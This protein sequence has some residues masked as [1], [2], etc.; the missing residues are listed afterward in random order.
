MSAN[1]SSSSVEIARDYQIPRNSLALLMVAQA[2]V[3]LPHAAHIS[4]WIVAAALTAGYWRWMVYLGR[5]NYPARWIKTVLVGASGI[6]VALSGS[7]IFSLETFTSL[8]IVAFALKLL[9]MR[10]RRDAYLVIFLG[11]FLVATE[12]LFDQSI[13]I[14]LYELFAAIVVTA[15]MISLN[16]L[17]TRVRPL[18]S[19]KLALTLVFQALP[20]MLVLFLFFPRIAPLWSVPLPSSG[21]TGI[22]DQVAPGDFASLSKSDEIA[23]SVVFKGDIPNPR[24]LYWRGLVYSYF[25]DGLWS[26]VPLPEAEPDTEFEMNVVPGVA[27]EE[28]LTYQVLLEPTQARWLFGLMTPRVESPG[29]ILTADYRLLARDPVNYLFRYQITSRSGIRVDQRLPEWLKRRETR[30][31][32]DGNPRTLAL[33]QELSARTNSPEAYIA[34]VLNRIRVEPFRYTLEPPKLERRNSID[35]FWFDTK[36]GFCTHYAGAFV[37]LMRAAGIPAR[38]VGGY[39]GGDINPLDGHIV[40]RQYDAHAWAEVWLPGLGW[41]RKDP[42]GAVAPE[43][44]EQGL[45]AALSPEDRSVLAAYT[46][47]GL[48]DLPGLADLSYFMESLQHRW[49]MWVVGYDT[50]LQANYLRELIGKVTPARVGL[51]LLVGGAFSVGLVLLSLFW[52]GRAKPQHPVVKLFLSFCH[53]LERS[54]IRRSPME[55]PAGF[56][57]RLVGSGDTRYSSL[58]DQVDTLIY[59]PGEKWDSAQLR[60]LRVGLQRL[61]LRLLFG[62]LHK[63]T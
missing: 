21:K 55:S 7:G 29:V 34:E 13:A 63:E 49:N 60:Q 42:T 26:Q 51:I 47:R 12:F 35:A 54:G 15:A 41:V 43:R 18:A 19:M 37:F 58:I 5:W 53:S 31:P 61:R 14:T 10:S 8:L 20:L 27:D 62:N 23:F 40:V 9:E 59:N 4:L 48:G 50:T 17:H 38:M 16:Q 24:S 22:T 28:T 45:D 46:G 1:S 3:V 25:S 57:R 33:A 52:R 36:A 30:L 32:A 2:V 56:L 39:Q 6:A 44:I 11:Y